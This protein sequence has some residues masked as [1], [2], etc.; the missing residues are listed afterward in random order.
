MAAA[1]APSLCCCCWED[2]AAAAVEAGDDELLLLLVLADLLPPLLAARTI[3]F[4]CRLT[5]IALYAC[6]KGE[7]TRV[8]ISESLP[9]HFLQTPKIGA[10]L[11]II[12]RFVNLS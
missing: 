10:V 7:K 6:C 1:A 2:V 11:M 4:I 9:R 8:N 12:G 3:S 5:A